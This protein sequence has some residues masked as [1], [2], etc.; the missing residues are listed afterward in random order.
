[1]IVKNGVFEETYLPASVP[2]RKPQIAEILS[3]LSP[4]LS[5]HVPVNLW[6]HGPPGSGKTSGAMHVVSRLKESMPLQSAYVNCWEKRTFFEVLDEV[7]SQLRILRAEQHRV[8]TKL[9]R[10]GRHLGDQ[11]SVLVLDDIDRMKPAERAATVYNMATAASMGIVCIARSE[12]ALFDLDDRARS[13]LAPRLVRFAAY[14][15]K[16]LVSILRHRAEAGLS[17]SSCSAKELKEI[18]ACADGDARTAIRTLRNAA[19]LAAPGIRKLSLRGLRKQREQMETARN[20]HLL[21]S[22]TADHRI[23]HRIV[24]DFGQILSPDLW[25]QYLQRCESISRRPIAL[26][27]FWKYTGRLT[28]SG[29]I[30]SCQSRQKGNV[31]LLK[32]ATGCPA[33]HVTHERRG[34]QD[35]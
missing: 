5:G 6:L 19:E 13:R 21:Q 34:P 16:D 20:A 1:M 24:K 31:N 22:L 33:A 3:C 25:Q 9:E 8:S 35:R 27:T 15:Q 14:S 23:L 4:V 29:L 17:P 2:A 32:I 10:I 26:R 30:I 18:A 12:R 11:P 28:L 7:V